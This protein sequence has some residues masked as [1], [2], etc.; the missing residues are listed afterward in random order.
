M[1]FG[2]QEKFMRILR[3]IYAGFIIIS[4]WL[5][6]M[7]M[8]HAQDGTENNAWTLVTSDRWD[9]QLTREDGGIAANRLIHIFPSVSE[10]REAATVSAW[11]GDPMF[12]TDGTGHVLMA[13]AYPY[14]GRS[15][16]N[17]TFVPDGVGIIL[18]DAE[19]MAQREGL[20]WLSLRLL[21]PDEG[22]TWK[23]TLTRVSCSRDDRGC[24]RTPVEGGLLAWNVIKTGE[25]TPALVH[26]VSG[27]RP[28]NS[29]SV[30]TP[31]LTVHVT[32]KAP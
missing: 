26:G 24:V 2:H 18:V 10:D 4:V 19:S 20:T 15:L 31:A 13:T 25:P 7:A 11:M 27:H 6:G 22:A 1:V 28:R 23:P 8:A 17:G 12:K 30:M 14:S 3:V 16:G 29:Y 5:C 9:I 32:M 21:S